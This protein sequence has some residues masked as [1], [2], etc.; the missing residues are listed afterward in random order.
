MIVLNEALHHGRLV[1]HVLVFPG[2][3]VNK[4]LL[5]ALQPDDFD[6]YVHVYEDNETYDA[7]YIVGCY[8]EA[9]ANGHAKLGEYGACRLVCGACECFYSDKERIEYLKHVIYEL[10]LRLPLL[11]AMLE[12]IMQK[13]AHTRHANCN[14]RIIQRAFRECISNP[15]MSL[16]IRRLEREAR[17]LCMS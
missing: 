11:D 14:A 1:I 10:G 4:P 6:T 15:Y 17:E 5:R 13:E 16:C 8:A 12:R 2:E 3:Q 9:W 7:R